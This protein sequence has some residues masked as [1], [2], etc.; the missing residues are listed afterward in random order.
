MV[1]PY[2]CFENSYRSRLQESRFNVKDET[3][4]LSRKFGKENYHSKPRKIPTER[5]FGNIS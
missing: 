5:R 4:R 2:Q 3:D 1:F